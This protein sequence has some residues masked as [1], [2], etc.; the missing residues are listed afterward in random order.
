MIAGTYL[1]RSGVEHLLV[2][3]GSGC[4]TCGKPHQSPEHARTVAQHLGGTACEL[5]DTDWPYA[6]VAQ[7]KHPDHMVTVCRTHGSWWHGPRP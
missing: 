1:S 3:S 6:C 5:V 7:D 2:T 4:A